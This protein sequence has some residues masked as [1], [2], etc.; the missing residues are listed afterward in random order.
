MKPIEPVDGQLEAWCHIA[1]FGSFA[2]SR[3]KPD[4]SI[5]RTVQILDA[6]AL[7]KVASSLDAEVLLDFEHASHDGTYGDTT[8]AGWINKLEVRGDGSDPS[9]GLWALIRFTDVGMAAVTNRRLRYLSPVW[10][11]DAEDRP[12]RLLDACLTNK[13]NFGDALVPVVNKSPAAGGEVTPKGISNM[14]E[15]IALYGLPDTATEADILAAAQKR[16][17]EFDTLKKQVDDMKAGALKT[18]AE[19]FAEQNKACIKNKDAFVASYCANKEQTIA[20][21]ETFQSAPVTKTPAKAPDTS[22]ARV[23]ANKLE[24][25]DSLPE[26]SAKTSFLRANAV[27]INDL[28]NAKKAE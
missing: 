10:T 4:G 21:F 13:P 18:E 8:A 14:K 11:L 12:Q 20:V 23:F 9:D 3:K 27:E 25:Y 6:Q 17:E 22:T 19:Q 5:E 26:G 28:R 7:N 1:P 2:A 16:Q 15:L 24:E